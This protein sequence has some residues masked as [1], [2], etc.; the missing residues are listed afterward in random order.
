MYASQERFRDKIFYESKD[1]DEDEDNPSKNQPT[2]SL[3]SKLEEQSLTEESGVQLK[4]RQELSSS[5]KPES[6]DT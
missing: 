5:E 1:E 4:N 6:A 2:L 3:P